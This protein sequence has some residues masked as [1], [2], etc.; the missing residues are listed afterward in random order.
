MDKEAL[1]AHYQEVLLG[2]AR[3]LARR[4]RD[5]MTDLPCSLGDIDPELEWDR[6]PDWFT[7]GEEGIA[8]WQTDE[9][10][11]RRQAVDELARLMEEEGD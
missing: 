8:L 4:L 10:L 11:R 6:L 9:V 1:K 3:N 2:D 7:D 5:I